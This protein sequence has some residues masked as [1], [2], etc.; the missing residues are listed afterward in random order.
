M[1]IESWTE[2]SLLSNYMSQHTS[3]GGKWKSGNN[4]VDQST[5]RWWGV[6]NPNI[7]LNW[8]QNEP[9]H[10]DYEHCVEMEYKKSQYK[11]N[12]VRCEKFRNYVCEIMVEK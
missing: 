10:P 6:N 12:D 4:F 8:W 3:N 9:T 1:S 2:H 5:Y 7:Y 11:L